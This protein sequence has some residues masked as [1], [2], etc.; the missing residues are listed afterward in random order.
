M[1][2]TAGHQGNQGWDFQE[3]LGTK[4]QLKVNEKEFAASPWWLPTQR[5]KSN[6]YLEALNPN[7]GAVELTFR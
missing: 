1:H 4:I 5:D 7:Q 6:I 2:N 3:R